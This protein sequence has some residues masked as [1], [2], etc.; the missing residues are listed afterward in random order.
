MWKTA[1]Y[2]D[3]G[4]QSHY[5]LVLPGANN[6]DH[7]YDHLGHANR[8]SLAGMVSV[9]RFSSLANLLFPILLQFSGTHNAYAKPYDNS[10][11]HA[12]ISMGLAR[13]NDHRNHPTSAPVSL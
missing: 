3:A 4:T 5:G 12:Y 10:A 2:L 11:G 1:R 9:L 8:T 6:L 13:A 7:G